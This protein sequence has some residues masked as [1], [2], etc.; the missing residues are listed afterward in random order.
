MITTTSSH[1]Q[2]C[3]LTLDLAGIRDFRAA[4][5]VS[6]LQIELRARITA[7]VARQTHRGIGR[8]AT[9][10]QHDIVDADA[11]LSRPL[12]LEGLQ[13]IARRRTQKLERLGGN[14]YPRRQ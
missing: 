4:Q 11:V 8:D 14:I 12:A 9:A 1:R 2:R 6:G 7:E 3:N 5:I 13:L 10:L